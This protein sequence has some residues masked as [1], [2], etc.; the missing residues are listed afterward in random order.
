M[1]DNEVPEPSR[2]HLLIYNIYGNIINKTYVASHVDYLNFIME[3]AK[4]DFPK[5]FKTAIRKASYFVFIGFE[6]DKW[7]N[8][9]LLYILN[10]INNS[11]V[12]KYAVEE[13]SAEELYSKLSDSDLNI[14]FIEK[15]SEQFIDD[16]YKNE[17]LSMRKIVPQ[18]EYV[19][20]MILSIQET[21]GKI[22]DRIPF[23][24]PMEQ[25]KLNLDLGILEKD[26]NEFVN[27]LKKLGT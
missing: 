6:F 17:N 27:R 12:E 3:Y 5:N 22:K 7:Y 23:C 21:I 8:I 2:D 1:L 16:L 13:Q 19:M 10:I 11:G 20:K 26:K 18:K 25:H 14:F 4:E 24:D 15:N 9:L